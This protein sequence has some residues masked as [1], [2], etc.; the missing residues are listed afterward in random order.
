VRESPSIDPAAEMA[1]EFALAGRAII[2]FGY[3]KKRR[4]EEYEPVADGEE[5]DQPGARRIVFV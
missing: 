5:A 4:R 2:A 3:R 1:M